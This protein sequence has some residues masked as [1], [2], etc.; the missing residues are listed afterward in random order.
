MLCKYLDLGAG[1]GRQTAVA[2][3]AAAVTATIAADV[4]ATATTAA[5]NC[6]QCCVAGGPTACGTMCNILVLLLHEILQVQE[7]YSQYIDILTSSPANTLAVR[8]P[9]RSGDRSH[10]AATHGTR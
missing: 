10:S 9:C 1:T 3:A 8:D 5:M 2:P 4:A 6:C 7:Q